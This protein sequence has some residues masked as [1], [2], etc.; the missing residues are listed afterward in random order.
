VITNY[1]TEPISVKNSADS[2]YISHKISIRGSLNIQSLHSIPRRQQR[3]FLHR[4]FPITSTD[5]ITL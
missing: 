2:I 1:T 5:H 3:H 4:L